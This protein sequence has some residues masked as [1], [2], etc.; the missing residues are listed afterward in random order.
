MTL[1]GVPL[2]GLTAPAILA[3]AVILVLTGRIVPRRL[4]MDKINE[5]KQWK[6]AFETE[7]EARLLSD[8]QT[9]QLLAATEVNREILLALGK[10][11]HPDVGLG[12]SSDE[13]EKG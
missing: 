5:A 1:N 6:E 3:F 8:H 9:T 10:V 12:G 2:F 7:R 4:Y 11:L 13:A